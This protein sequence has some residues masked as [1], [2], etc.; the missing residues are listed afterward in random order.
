MGLLTLGLSAWLSEFYRLPRQVIRWI[1]FA[2]LGYGAF[3]ALVAITVV[4]ALRTGSTGRVSAGRRLVWTL[5]AANTAWAGVC[6][7]L[8]VVYATEASLFGCAHLA[9]EGLFVLG[10]AM[11]EYRRVLPLLASS[12]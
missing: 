11:L 7:W 9:L 10:L 12:G 2:N 5:L 1:G 6:V 4:G 8:L 3:A